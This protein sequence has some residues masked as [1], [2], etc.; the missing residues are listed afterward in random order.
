MVGRVLPALK[1]PF[2][3]A[4]L[5]Y[6]NWKDSVARSLRKPEGPSCS[7][8]ASRKLL[9]LEAE[10]RPLWHPGRS[11]VGAAG[12]RNRVGQLKSACPRDRSC[13]PVQQAGRL[14]G[15]HPE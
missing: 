14:L 7:A 13:G 4:A 11:G 9:G 1:P 12:S 5:P 15:L 8:G 2:S 10:V 3:W 6:S